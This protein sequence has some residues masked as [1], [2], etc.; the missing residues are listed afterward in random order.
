MRPLDTAMAGGDDTDD[1]FG[2][3]PFLGKL[4]RHLGIQVDHQPECVVLKDEESR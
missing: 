2:F 1:S 3:G 4:L